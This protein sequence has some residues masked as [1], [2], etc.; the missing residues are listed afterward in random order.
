MLYMQNKPRMCARIKSCV[1]VCVRVTDKFSLSNIVA[2]KSDACVLRAH[3]VCVR[4][5][6]CYA[7]WFCGNGMWLTSVRF[8]CEPSLTEIEILPHAGFLRKTS[9]CI[10]VNKYCRLTYKTVN[11][12]HTQL[13]VSNFNS[14]HN[15][16]SRQFTKPGNNN[17][18]NARAL[19]QTQLSSDLYSTTTILA[20]RCVDVD[21][22]C[23]LTTHTNTRSKTRSPLAVISLAIRFFHTVSV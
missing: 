8:F 17:D 2:L 1:C 9:F 18:R 11:G 12:Q 13:P 21:F 16:H 22:F 5:F 19:V 10:A 7:L 20:P 14:T 23:F 15:P 6:F 4:V 3:G